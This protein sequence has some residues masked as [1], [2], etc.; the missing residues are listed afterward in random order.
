[1]SQST[2]A[3][4]SITLTVI[5]NTKDTE[6]EFPQEIKLPE[7]IIKGYKDLSEKVEAAVIKIHKR[8]KN[9]KK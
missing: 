5:E 8:R 3:I 9:G 6:K 2:V 7:E 4:N 1:M